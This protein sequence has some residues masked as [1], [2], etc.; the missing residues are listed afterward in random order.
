MMIC[1]RA[2]VPTVHEALLAGR[3]YSLVSARGVDSKT[4]YV[5]WYMYTVMYIAT[6]LPVLRRFAIRAMRS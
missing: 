1:P 4:V 3:R 5:Y 6:P 2:T